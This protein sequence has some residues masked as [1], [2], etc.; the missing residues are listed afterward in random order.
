MEYIITLVLNDT[1][2]RALGQDTK[3]LTVNANL[4]D[5]TGEY[6]DKLFPMSLVENFYSTKSFLNLA[7]QDYVCVVYSDGSR[8]LGVVSKNTFDK[9]RM[10]VKI[11]G[12]SDY[13][14][15]EFNANGVQATHCKSKMHLEFITPEEVEEFKTKMK[16]APYMQVLEALVDD[17]FGITIDWKKI[18]MPQWLSYDAV[19]KIQE[20]L[21][22]EKDN[23][24][25]NC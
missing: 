9:R 25:E 3:T 1:G 4:T 10:S 5:I 23:F 6:L 24:D 2:K 21:N 22:D 17:S 13:E 16:N 7:D 12:G 19:S 11:Y 14:W 18:K 15:H 20:I 8:H